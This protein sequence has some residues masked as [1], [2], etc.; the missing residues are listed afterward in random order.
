M[1][2]G[3]Q[4]LPVFVTIPEQR[5]IASVWNH[6][7]NMR[8][9]GDSAFV[10]ALAHH[11][12]L[13]ER[14]LPAQREQALESGCFSFPV[15]AVPTLSSGTTLLFH[16][17]GMGKASPSMASELRTARND[18]RPKRRSGHLSVSVWPDWA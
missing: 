8:R 1:T 12:F 18:T 7:V 11:G 17:L 13:P 16:L 14:S 6:M 15:P 3:T 2:G 9:E 4:G 5:L 10:C